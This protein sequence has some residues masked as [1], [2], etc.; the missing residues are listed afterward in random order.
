MKILFVLATL[1]HVASIV[2][3][4]VPMI[5]STQPTAVTTLNLF[6][7]NKKKAAGK[8]E[9]ESFSGGAPRI[10]IRE[11]EDNAMW[12]EEPGDLKKKQDAK[13]KGGK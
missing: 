10:T 9:D 7:G 6:G 11:D 3:A 5:P 2:S 4:F 13:K 1:V 12:I 8:K